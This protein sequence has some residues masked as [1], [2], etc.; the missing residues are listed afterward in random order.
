MAP[1]P[2]SSLQLQTFKLTHLVSVDVNG[3][4]RFTVHQ[5]AILASG[6][7]TRPCVLL[8]SASMTLAQMFS[9]RV[10]AGI[11]PTLNAECVLPAISPKQSCI[12]FGQNSCEGPTISNPGTHSVWSSSIVKHSFLVVL[13]WQIP[14]H[15][16]LKLLPVCFTSQMPKLHAIW[17][18]N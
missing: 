10:A 7:R 18:I 16:L 4:N 17:S 9:C 15:L 5:L 12:W 6:N 11:R 2:N 1:A 13:T 8:V 14:T 3:W